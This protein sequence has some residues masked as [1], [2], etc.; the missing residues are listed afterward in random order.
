MCWCLTGKVKNAMRFALAH[1]GEMARWLNLIF[2]VL[3]LNLYGSHLSNFSTSSY[4][5]PHI[6][7][8][9]TKLQTIL[10]LSGPYDNFR[11]TGMTNCQR[12]ITLRPELEFKHDFHFFSAHFTSKITFSAF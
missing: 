11:M 5:I 12:G 2:R 9:G 8:T 4:L 10:E 6:S 3:Y 1:S 7:Y